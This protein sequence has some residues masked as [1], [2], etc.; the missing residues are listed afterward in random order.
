MGTPHSKLVDRG[1]RTRGFDAHIWRRALYSGRS[2]HRALGA[3]G[4]VPTHE[5]L[6]VKHVLASSLRGRALC[7][8]LE[9]DRTRHFSG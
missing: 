5:A 1:F 6:G 9:A 4:L 3:M 8:R 7:K 2:A